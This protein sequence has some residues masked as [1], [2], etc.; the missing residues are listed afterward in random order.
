MA[1]RYC[2]LEFYVPAEYCDRVKEA[3]FAAGAGSLG[4]YC[5]CA[6]ECAG[7]G[8]FMPLP[9]SAP[10]I[11]ETGRL[12]RVAEIKVEVLVPMARLREVIAALKAAHPYETP[13]FY[14]FEAGTE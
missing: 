1:E 5:R 11:G 9:G 10:F 12:E 3:V 6:W 4:N 7:T 2:K 13:A 14:W 8:Q